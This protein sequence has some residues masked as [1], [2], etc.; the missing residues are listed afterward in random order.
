MTKLKNPSLFVS[1]K[2]GLPISKKDAESVKF[3]PA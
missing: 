2:T 1:S 3:A